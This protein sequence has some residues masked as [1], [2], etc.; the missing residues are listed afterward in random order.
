V[1]GHDRLRYWSDNKFV[2]PAQVLADN[3]QLRLLRIG[4]EAYI[5]KKDRIDENHQVVSLIMLLKE[6]TISN[7]YLEPEWNREV[8]PSPN[9]TVLEPGATSGVPVCIADNCL[10][11]IDFPDASA[12]NENLRAVAVIFFVLSI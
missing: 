4:R 1:Y 5:L 9:F 8:F 7:D 12:V 11:R 6:Y 2:P 10:F 3:F